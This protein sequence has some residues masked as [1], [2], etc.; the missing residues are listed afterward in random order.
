MRSRGQEDFEERDVEQARGE[1]A[2]TDG[3]QEH[4]RGEVRT[5]V[6]EKVAGAA[7]PAKEGGQGEA[8]DGIEAS[9]VVRVAAEVEV[10]EVQAGSAAEDRGE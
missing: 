5:V 4:D 1:Q 2:G 3:E 9:A 10:T 8:V 7:E 6:A